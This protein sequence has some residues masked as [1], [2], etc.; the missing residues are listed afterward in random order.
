MTVEASTQPP[1]TATSPVISP[2]RIP[3][4]RLL[5]LGATAVSLGVQFYSVALVWLVLYLTGSGLQLGA[6][7]TVAAIPRA[8]SMLLSGALIDRYPPRQILIISSLFN[9]IL[10]S[11]VVL[12]LGGGWMS[13]TTLFIVAPITGLMDAIFYPTNTA[14]IPRLVDK[15]RLAPANALI[16]TAD[17]LANIAGPSLGGI[18]IGEVGRLT[19][20]PEAGLMAGFAVN[21]VLFALGFLVFLNLSRKTDKATVSPDEKPEPLGKAVV[22]GIRYALT[23]PPIRIS[24]LLIALLNFAAIGPIV[25]GGALLV[26]RRFGGDATMYGIMT[27]AFGIGSLVGAFLISLMGEIKR[28]GMTL[29]YTAFALAV[30]LF[31]LG[32]AP[33]FWVAFGVCFMI[34]VFGSITNINAVTWLQ[35][36]TDMHMQGR[37]ASL[38]VFAAVALDPFSNAI[39]GAIAEFDVTLLFCAAGALVGI[40]GIVA[41]FNP[42]LREER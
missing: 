20:T 31:T 23:K 26:E 18:L 22:S 42:T 11:I 25:V 9:G 3:D 27:G 37:I 15:A 2:I 24:L 34:G 4:F 35:I 16:Q 36:K 32:F 30:G 33:S 28:P 12:L 19:G 14:L 29:V 6:L 17:T 21:T 40:G 7:L 39:S 38:V 10:M 5:W 1:S 13:M 8:I 41:L